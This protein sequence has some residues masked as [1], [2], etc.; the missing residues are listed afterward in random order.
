M[1]NTMKMISRIRW[2]PSGRIHG[3]QHTRFLGRIN[4]LERHTLI[5]YDESMNQHT[6]TSI[7]QN[8]DFPN[9]A[10][11][12]EIPQVQEQIKALAQEIL[13]NGMIVEDLRTR[14]ASVLPQ[15]TGAQ[16]GASASRVPE[17]YLVPHADHLRSL[18]RAVRN[19]NLGLREILSQI[20][21]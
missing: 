5:L 4:G 10:I 2:S 6:A 14:L 7:G 8:R 9:T 11:E 17:E 12:P 13:D 20:Q 18:Y 19:Q 16:D 21:L 1:K 15:P 3:S